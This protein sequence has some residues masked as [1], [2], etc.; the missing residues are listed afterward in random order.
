MIVAFK[1]EHMSK[2]HQGEFF[3]N[4]ISFALQK[5]KIEVT[6]QGNVGIDG[7]LQRM[8]YNIGTGSTQYSIE[9]AKQNFI[10]SSYFKSYA[11]AHFWTVYQIKEKII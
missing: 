3:E 10:N 9:E 11:K 1:H 7:H 4:L 2:V 6:E 8:S 5:F